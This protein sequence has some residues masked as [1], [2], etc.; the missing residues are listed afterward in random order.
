MK[1]LKLLELIECIELIK[2]NELIGFVHQTIELIALVQVRGTN[3]ISWSKATY[4]LAS[5]TCEVIGLV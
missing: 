5:S 3:W 1:F 2:V 4:W